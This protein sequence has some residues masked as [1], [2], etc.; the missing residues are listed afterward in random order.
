[1]VSWLKR[2]VRYV[3]CRRM[4]MSACSKLSK[5][6]PYRMGHAVIGHSSAGRSERA[7]CTARCIRCLFPSCAHF[8]L[9]GEGKKD[10]TGATG[11]GSR[12]SV[13]DG[14]DGGCVA[15]GISGGGIGDGCAANPPCTGGCQGSGGAEGAAGAGDAASGGGMVGTVRGGGTIN[16][17]ARLLRPRCAAMEESPGRLESSSLLSSLLSSSH[18][19][20]CLP[21]VDAC[22]LAAS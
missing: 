3:L 22:S 20:S 21:T 1:M 13:V 16:S 10:T 11:A 6:A 18:A 19:C 2:L 4:Y 15:T 5:S 9:L 8:V 7:L 12:D 14:S 17:S